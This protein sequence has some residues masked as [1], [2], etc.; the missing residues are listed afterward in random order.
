MSFVWQIYF[1]LAVGAFGTA[2]NIINISVL[3]NPKLKDTSYR[4]MLIKAISDIIYLILSVSYNSI[5]SCS[6]CTSSYISNAYS[7]AAGI[8]IMPSLAIF[9]TLI[10]IILSV[11]IF[12]ILANRDWFTKR[13]FWITVVL[14]AFISSVFYI[15]KPFALNVAY[16]P[17][18]DSFYMTYSSFSLT[19]TYQILT[20]LQYAVRIVL[21]VGILNVLNIVNAVKFRKRFSN[22]LGVFNSPSQTGAGLGTGSGSKVLLTSMDTRNSKSVKNITKMAIV[23]AF[24][25]IFL[26][27]PYFICV[28][29]DLTGFKNPSFVAFHYLSAGLVF[30]SP[31]LIF[32]VYYLFNKNY[33]NIL[34]GYLRL[35]F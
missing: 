5:N 11:Y 20:I 32:L 23:S 7:I 8:Y 10:E 17:T 21:C 26:E 16:N 24:F 2:T 27:M 25:K 1:N 9:S 14:A 30:L 33:R 28:I 15:S 4:Y 18:L 6:N 12:S 29:I 34:N 13:I 19:Q 3:I 31:S 35:K 22:R